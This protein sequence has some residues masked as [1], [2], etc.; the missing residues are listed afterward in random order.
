MRPDASD[1][2]ASVG[3]RKG[4]SKTVI[5]TVVGLAAVLAIGLVAFM[6]LRKDETP[7]AT[8]AKSLPQGAMAGGKG[9][10]VFADKAKDSAKTVD[11]YLDFQCPFCGKF[12]TAQGEKLTELAKSGDIKLN[13]H[14]KTFLDENIPGDNSARAANAA[15]CSANAGKF[16]EFT[17]ETF[18]NQPEEGKGYTQDDLLEFGKNVG[19]SDGAESAF[20]SCVKNNTYGSYVEQ[21]E[22]QTNKDGVNSTPV[23]KINGKDVENADMAGMMNIEGSTPTTI[24]KVLAKS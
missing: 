1:K 6:S 5:A 16:A 3:P 14:V 15:F 21:T 12:E 23:V 7:Q 4:P 24:D 19:I 10:P 11:V 22:E 13:Y 9:M 17:R 8:S 2:L 18:E 20:A